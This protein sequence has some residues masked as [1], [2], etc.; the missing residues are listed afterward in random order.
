M[1]PE[2]VY[3]LRFRRLRTCWH[4]AVAAVLAETLSAGE[5]VT[6]S[7]LNSST[8]LMARSTELLRRSQA[9][10]DSAEAHLGGAS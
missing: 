10:L 6:L 5:V 2:A 4:P 1:I 3:E 7:D 8:R 9:L